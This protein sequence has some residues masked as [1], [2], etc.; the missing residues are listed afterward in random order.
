MKKIWIIISIVIVLIAILILYIIFSNKNK[1][2]NNL[3]SYVYNTYDDNGNI[4]SNTLDYYNSSKVTNY[5][6]LDTSKGLIIIQLYPDIAPITV[7]NFQSLVKS[8]FYTNM[9]FHRVIKGFMIQTGDPT[10]TGTGGSSKTIKGEFS[11]NNVTNDLSHVRG[12]V[13]MARS[14]T[15]DSASSQFFIVQKDSTYLDGNYAA[16]GKVIAGMEV[17]D[18]IANVKTDSN[19]KPT[20]N[21]TLN[22]INFITIK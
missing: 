10:G 16:F 15:N 11:S 12:V 5:V 17:V 2:D 19:D 13:S 1:E 20:S 4:V 8:K 7:A 22:S 3:Q 14:K 18:K 6:K 9:I 21:I